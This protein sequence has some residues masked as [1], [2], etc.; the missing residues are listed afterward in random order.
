MV[1][2]S[3]DEL[4]LSGMLLRSGLF[5]EQFESRFLDHMYKLAEFTEESP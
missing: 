4:Q 3:L 1:P 2:S 5:V